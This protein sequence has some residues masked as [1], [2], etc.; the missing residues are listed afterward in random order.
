MALRQSAN[1]STEH[2]QPFVVRMEPP[3]VVPMEGPQSSVD[4]TE[5]RGSDRGYAWS[6]GAA[7]P[8]DVPD[9]AGDSL[10][11]GWEGRSSCHRLRSD[12]RSARNGSRR[13]SGNSCSGSAIPAL[14]SVSSRP[15]DGID[16]DLGS[17]QDSSKR[18]VGNRFPRITPLGSPRS[19]SDNNVPAE[20]AWPFFAIQDV[21]TSEIR[22]GRCGALEDLASGTGGG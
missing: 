21:S 7:N 19:L 2:Q 10:C 3:F 1:Q 4:H 20:M 6:P 18:R 12:S 13:S 9:R 22:I 8:I 11:S 14:V 17:R 5:Y 16:W 15:F